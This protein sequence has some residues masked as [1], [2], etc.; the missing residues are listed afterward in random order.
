M[1][2]TALVAIVAIIAA[3][4]R[5]VA[6]ARAAAAAAAAAEAEVRACCMAGLRAARSTLGAAATPQHPQLCSC[7]RPD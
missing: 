6:A 2:C 4:A 7:R 3:A 5:K 1:R